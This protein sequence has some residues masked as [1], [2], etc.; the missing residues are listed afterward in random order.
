MW[1]LL[2]TTVLNKLFYNVPVHE[3]FSAEEIDLQISSVSGVC[4]QEIQS[5]LADLKAHQGT[6]TV[7][8]ALLRKAITAC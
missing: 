7:V 2:G 3:R 8:L 6:T 1:L 5:L 4:N